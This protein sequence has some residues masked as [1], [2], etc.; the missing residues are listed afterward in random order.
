MASENKIKQFA[1]EAGYEPLEGRCIIVRP[2]PDNLSDKI[3]SFLKSFVECDMCVLQMCQH[4]LILLPFHP[5]WA[6]LRKDVSL[7]LPYGE[8]QSVELEDDLLDTVITI[9]TEEDE[10]RLTTQ[11]KELSDFRMS[12]LHATQYAGGYKN[13][14]KENLEGTLKTLRQFGNGV[15]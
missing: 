8:I 12:G 3:V 13:W 7:V 4:E 10:I 14:H 11:Q 2:A 15:S 1:R 6:S 9:H 5:M